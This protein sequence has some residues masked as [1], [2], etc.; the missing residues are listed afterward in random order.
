MF[1]LVEVCSGR[2][3][4]HD[5]MRQLKWKCANECWLTIGDLNDHMCDDNY[6]FCTYMDLSAKRKCIIACTH[7]LLPEY[8][9]YLHV[10]CL[11][12]T[13]HFNL[14]STVMKE[15]MMDTP[16]AVI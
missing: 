8:E 12:V 6:L 4:Q 14:Q 3:H 1:C 7:T 5:I 16:V 9:T 11:F 15:E 2:G 13:D 10:H